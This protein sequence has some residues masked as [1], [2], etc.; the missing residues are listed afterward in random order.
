MWIGQVFYSIS[1]TFLKCSICVTLL[2]IAVKRLHRIIIW[3][4][5]IFTIIAMLYNTIG[6][7]IICMPLTAI[8][9]NHGKCLIPFLMSLAY[10]VSISAVVTDWICAILP[11][12]MLYKSNMKRSTKV[13]VT[14]ILGLAV[15]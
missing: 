10:V 11:I 6:V 5:I 8:W 14:I 7:F 15:L 12:F 2:R 4:T 9:D 13:S 1:T 3:S